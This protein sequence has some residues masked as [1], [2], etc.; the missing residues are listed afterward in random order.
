M[1][2]LPFVL[3][4][5]GYFFKKKLANPGLFFVYFRSMWKNDN[6]IQYTARDL[7]PRPLEHESSPITTRPGLPPTDR[8]Y[9]NYDYLKSPTTHPSG[10][11]WGHQCLLMLAQ[12]NSIKSPW[13][14]L[15]PV[16]VRPKARFKPPLASKSKVL[17]SPPT[18]WSQINVKL[19]GLSRF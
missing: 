18:D 13:C 1:V 19:H 3:K 9:L 17:N 14:S 2:M 16:T 4:D 7:N 12:T 5:R 8:G 10:I 15:S 6:S 11:Y